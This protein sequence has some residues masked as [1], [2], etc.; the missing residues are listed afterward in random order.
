MTTTAPRPGGSTNPVSQDSTGPSPR[1][2]VVRAAQAAMMASGEVVSPRKVNRIAERFWRTLNRH[3]ITF[4]EFLTNETARSRVF[5]TDNGLRTLS[6][7]LDI[8][9]ERAVRNV[10]HQR[11]Y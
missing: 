9:G 7:Y 10:M 4:H 8:T 11:G 3:R 2:T 6:G 1:E 5:A